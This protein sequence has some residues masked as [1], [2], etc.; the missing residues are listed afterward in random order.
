MVQRLPMPP[1]ER[2]ALLQ[3]TARIGAVTA[4]AVAHH[5]GT[6]LASARARLS[7]AVRDQLLSRRRPLVGHPAL[8]TVTRAGLRAAGLRG[9]DPVRVSAASSLHMIVCARVA[10]ALESCYPD[11]TVGGE[12]EL[13]HE[14]RESG[15]PRA[16]ASLGVGADGRSLLH[17]RSEE[18]R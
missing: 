15:G 5:Q 10:A 18:R 4:E 17:R 3:W 14:E 1:C 9:I 8:Y 2:E 7:L 11:H 16:S 13:R 12:R 6:T